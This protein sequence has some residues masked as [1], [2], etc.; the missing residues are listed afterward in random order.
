LLDGRLATHYLTPKTNSLTNLHDQFAWAQFEPLISAVVFKYSFTTCGH[1]CRGP[2]ITCFYFKKTNKEFFL[3]VIFLCRVWS[4]IF[5]ESNFN[6]LNHFAQVWSC[7][8]FLMGCLLSVL[9]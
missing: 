4:K 8:Y 6:T 3:K 7:Q 2:H 5:L 9:C 1:T